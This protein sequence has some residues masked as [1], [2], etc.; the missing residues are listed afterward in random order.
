MSGKR[1]TFLSY[2]GENLTNKGKK[3]I[4]QIFTPKSYLGLI[5]KNKK[6]MPFFKIQ[7]INCKENPNVLLV[8]KFLN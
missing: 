4:F 3:Q 2:L 8:L 1:N 7:E 6:S 5:S